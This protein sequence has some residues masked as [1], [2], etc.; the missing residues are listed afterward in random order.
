MSMLVRAPFRSIAARQPGC[1]STGPMSLRALSQSSTSTLAQKFEVILGD[2]IFDVLRRESSRS[3]IAY[4][5][6][7][8]ILFAGIQAAGGQRWPL[9]WW[10]SDALWLDQRRL[11]CLHWISEPNAVRHGLVILVGSPYRS[12]A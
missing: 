8:P 5:V 1:M 10:R 2:D 11:H 12:M 9:G 3:A 6:A 4:L 7:L